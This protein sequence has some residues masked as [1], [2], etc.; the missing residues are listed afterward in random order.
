VELTIGQRLG[1]VLRGLRVKQGWNLEYVGELCG[2][3]GANISRIEL[4]RPTEYR[5]EL[6]EKIASAFGFRLYELFAL[7]EDVRLA[8]KE[9]LTADEQ[10]LL[11]IYRA[12]PPSQKGKVRNV[13]QALSLPTE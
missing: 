11:A 7:V 3:T 10:T 8:E 2:T 6:L 12:L 4:A 1:A 9:S 13:A 5:L